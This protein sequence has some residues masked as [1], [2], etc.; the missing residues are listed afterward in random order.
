MV[1]QKKSALIVLDMVIDPLTGDRALKIISD[2]GIRKDLLLLCTL[3]M[4][5]KA[6]PQGVH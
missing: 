6:L 1:R 3:D 5:A 4:A 2:L